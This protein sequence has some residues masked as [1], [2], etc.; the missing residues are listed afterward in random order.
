MCVYVFVCGRIIQYSV[1]CNRIAPLS[2]RTQLLLYVHGCV[3]E[4][5]AAAWDT[6]LHTFTSR[7]TANTVTNARA[8]EEEEDNA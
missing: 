5:V 6:S 3:G 4:G 1:V 7:S 8:E 2:T